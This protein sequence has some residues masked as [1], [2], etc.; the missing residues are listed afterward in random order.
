MQNPAL[1]ALSDRH[2]NNI[3]YVVPVVIMLTVVVKM[4]VV[5]MVTLMI[6]NLMSA[7]T[8]LWRWCC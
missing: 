8:S 2:L 5:R 3:V 1:S 7:V 6:K 4:V